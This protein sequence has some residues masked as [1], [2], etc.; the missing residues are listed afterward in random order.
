MSVEVTAEPSFQ[1]A[2]DR[3]LNVQ[4]VLSEFVTGKSD[5]KS[6]TTTSP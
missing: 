3:I 2:S 1:R 5:A 6:G 4:E